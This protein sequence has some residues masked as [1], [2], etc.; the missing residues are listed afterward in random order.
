MKKDIGSIFP[1]TATDLSLSKD[2]V[3][4]FKG[5]MYNRIYFSLCREAIYAVAKKYEKSKKVVLIPAYTC[6]TVIEPFEQQGWTYYFYNIKKNLRIDTHNLLSLVNIYHPTIIVVHPYYGMELNL[7]ELKVLYKIKQSGCILLEDITQCIYTDK[8]PDIFDYFVGS[9]RKWLKI[10]DGA[11]LESTLPNESIEQPM[12]EN[13]SFIQKQIDAM[14]LRGKYF[15]LGDEE[16]KSISI[17]INKEAAAAVANNI[18]CHK[19]ANFSKNILAKGDISKYVEK[20]FSNYKYLFK[21]INA[22][23]GVELT[24][25]CLEEVTTAPLYFPFYADDRANLQKALAKEHIYAP[26]LWPVNTEKVLINENIKYIYS[27]IIAIPIDQRYNLDDMCKIS[28]I[29]KSVYEK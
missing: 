22:C 24:C 10:P 7:D 4:V 9:S 3:N 11:F 23:G 26:V 13:A 12:I 20:R 25:S 1:L 29:I 6:Q 8:R 21:H 17:R 15:E 16:I 18:K 19:M 27:H 2:D 5:T 28:D 14:Y